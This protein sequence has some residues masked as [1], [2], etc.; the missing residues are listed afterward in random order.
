M[1]SQGPQGRSV[2]DSLSLTSGAGLPVE[3][4][5]TV[6]SPGTTTATATAQSTTPATQEEPTRRSGRAIKRKKF[7]DEFLVRSPLQQITF[8]ILLT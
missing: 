1:D 6:S 2:F 5:N 8:L 7:D 4:Q 3:F